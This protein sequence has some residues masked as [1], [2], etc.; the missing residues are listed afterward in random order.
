MFD[1][2][3]TAIV[4]SVLVIAGSASQALEQEKPPGSSPP[5]DCADGNGRPQLLDVPT[6]RDPYEAS[7]NQ[8][9]QRGLELSSSGERTAAVK[10]FGQALEERPADA[11]FVDSL[12]KLYI[13]DSQPNAALEVIRAYTKVC[14]VTAF[15]YALEAEVL[16]QQKQYD[17][18]ASAIVSSLELFSDNARMHYLL[19]L[20]LLLK[21]DRVDASFELNKAENLSPNDADIRYFYGR[22]LYLNGYY[23]AARDQFLACL[24]VDPQHRKAQENL[25]LSYEA[26]RDYA[27]ARRS[28]EQAIER[29]RA[30]P[31][32]A[33]HG[34]P[35]GYYG[36]MLLEMNEPKHALEVLQEGVTASPRSLVVNFQLGR[37]LYALNQLDQARHFLLIAEE[38][39]PNYA[40]TH[41]LLGRLYSKQQEN[42]KATQEFQIFHELNKESANREF[43]LTD[44]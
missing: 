30:Q 10:E 34:E 19:G 25:G 28:Y 4:L 16:F 22:A 36:A 29:E 37:V 26:M 3:L 43:P 17:S 9:Y 41:Y 33:K 35:F 14:G 2:M 21:S 38:L 40:Q 32:S 31:P 5:T 20:I 39:A 27:S 23:P 11:R 12:A 18:A 42:Q 15:G 1:T 13:L 6:A 8:H 44:R 24:K 7:S